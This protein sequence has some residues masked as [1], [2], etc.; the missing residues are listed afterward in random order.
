MWHTGAGVTFSGTDTWKSAIDGEGAFVRKDSVFRNWIVA[1][2]SIP[3]GTAKQNG[4]VV[5]FSEPGRFHLYGERLTLLRSC[6][7][8]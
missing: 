7:V 6:V 2:D 3:L 5:A 1:K 4:R 8:V